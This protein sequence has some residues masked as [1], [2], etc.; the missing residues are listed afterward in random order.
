MEIVVPF[1]IDDL[2]KAFR[3]ILIPL[4]YSLL[5]QVLPGFQPFV[6]SRIP[7]FSLTCMKLSDVFAIPGPSLL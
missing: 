6:A 4:L 3:Y 7:I 2:L 5:T 1:G